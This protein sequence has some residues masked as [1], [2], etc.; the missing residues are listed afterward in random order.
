MIPRSGDRDFDLALAHTL[1]AVSEKL[2]ALP[3]FAYYDDYDGANAYATPKVRM[4]NADGTVLF[5]QRLLSRLM[6]GTESPEV[7]VAAVCAHEFGHILQFKRGLDR[8]VGVGQPTVKRVEL[9]ADF[10][11]GYFA[12]ARKLERPNFPA[13][14][15]AM[16]QHSFGD[17]MVNHPG[18]HGTS[19]E[20]GAAIA[21]GFEAAY[22][23]KCTL[24][25]AIQISTNYV[26]GL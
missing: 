7:A 13:A 26:A 2:E 6:S 21:K 19:E 10:F 8:V 1:A 11:A 15:F 12:G 9:Q 4:N 22:R 14:V 16:T 25:Q 3:S 5:G 17:N 18:H 23:E 20:R 24:A